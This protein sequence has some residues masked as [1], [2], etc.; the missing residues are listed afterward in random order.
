[1]LPRYALPLLLL[2]GARHLGASDADINTRDTVDD[3][4]AHHLELMAK[5][6]MSYEEEV[7]MSYEEM[8]EMMEEHWPPRPPQPLPSPSPPSQGSQVA[9]LADVQEALLTRRSALHASSPP[10]P[11]PS[12]PTDSVG[13]DPLVVGDHSQVGIGNVVAVHMVAIAGTNR[14]FFMERP[15]GKHPDGSKVIAGYWDVDTSTFTNV[16]ATDS[17]FCSGHT[18]TSAGDILVVGGHIAKTGYADGLRG[19]R[20]Y[21]ST[22]GSFTSIGRLIAPRW[23][24][25]ATLLPNNQIM[26][27]GSTIK[28]GS[29]T[30]SNPYYE[31]WN[32]R[33]PGTT[34]RLP[35]SDTFVAST[36]DI[37]YPAQYILPS[38]H[39]FMYCNV[40]GEIFNPMTAQTLSVIP[41][42]GGNM[43]V[44]TE[45]PY[46]G[47]SVM[48]PLTPAN[49]YTPEVVFFGGQY[50]YGWVNTTAP[51]LAWRIKVQINGTGSNACYG[52]GAGW[53]SERM[54]R[55]RVMPD[56]VLLPNGQVVVLNG[57]MRGV[58]G[59][60]VAGGMAKNNEPNMWPELYTPWAP[61]GSRFT[62][63]KRNL[64][65]RL[66]HSTAA[67]TM[68]G[69]ILVAGCDRCDKYWC[70]D[71][72]YS[73]SPWGLPDYRIELFRPPVY[74]DFS[75]KPT[76]ALV[77]ATNFGYNKPLTITY[78][79]ANASMQADSA[80]LVAPSATTHSTNMHQR[81]V[82]LKT[83]VRTQ[84]TPNTI[85]VQSPPNINIAPPGMYM[86]F[87]LNGRVYSRAV[88]VKLAP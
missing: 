21:N 53:Q 41:P 32:P 13:D 20:I 34:R 27:T 18:L 74:F 38:G 68:D 51:A 9:V 45:Y 1:M 33:S 16:A 66:Y 24:P 54:L 75:S 60:N 65:P 25:T 17:L 4:S 61:R 81:V 19:L 71:P 55:P 57:A 29:G 76:I 14:F 46:T 77:N 8:V 69:T 35:L 47:S 11:S 87:L 48:L 28:P 5:G 85:T 44:Y 7:D 49:K 40:Y 39:L 58:A 70:T 6:V 63:L 79:I 3:N 67:L 86:L 84:G 64:I 43:K 73:R 78:S 42:L 56:A 2:V 22:S 31:L 30:G 88:W 82:G 26:I 23:Y 36:G 62:P 59:D 80:V 52:Y 37:Y 72:H 12:P 15:S 50:S 10:S 83:L